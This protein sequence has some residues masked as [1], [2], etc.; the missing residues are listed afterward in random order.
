MIK[1]NYSNRAIHNVHALLKV[2]GSSGHICCLSGVDYKTETIWAYYAHQSKGIC[3]EYE[4]VKP[5]YVFEVQ[6]ENNRNDV[7]GTVANLLNSLQING[8]DSSDSIENRISTRILWLNRTIK[9]STWSH[10]RE[11]RIVIPTC[12]EFDHGIGLSAEDAGL[13][14]DGILSS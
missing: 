1:A 3:V 11:Y 5:D 13:K 8:A 10:E 14:L 4:V 9:S 2:A 6:Y 12:G 7:T